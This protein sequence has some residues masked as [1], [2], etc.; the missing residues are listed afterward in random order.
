MYTSYGKTSTSG[1]EPVTL[2][3]VE[4]AMPGELSVWTFDAGSGA[5]KILINDQE[6]VVEE[7]EFSMT[8]RIYSHGT[9]KVQIQRT[10]DTDMTG[11]QALLTQ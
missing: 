11:W 7:G 6:I 1:T 4:G 9:L 2:L 5:G 3:D 10:G 8:I